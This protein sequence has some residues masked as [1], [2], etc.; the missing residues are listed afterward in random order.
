[1]RF[2]SSVAIFASFLA[3][4]NADNFLGSC[5]DPWLSPD[6]LVLHV[7]CPIN[8]GMEIKGIVWSNCV[9]NDDRVLNCRRE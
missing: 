1:M 3:T 6:G 9:A 2:F 4:V 5:R 7:N 8:G